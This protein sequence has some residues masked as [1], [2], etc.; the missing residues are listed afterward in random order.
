MGMMP[1]TMGIVMPAA[2]ARD[3]EVEVDLGV[4]EEA[5]GHE[6]VDAR[7]DAAPEVRG[8]PIEIAA[9]DNGHSG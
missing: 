5:G 8:V 1:G 9:V 2:R 3:G 6:E 4:E 7:V